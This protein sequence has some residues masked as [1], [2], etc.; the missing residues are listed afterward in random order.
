MKTRI[1]IALML[2]LVFSFFC[3]MSAE[4]QRGPTKYSSTYAW[5]FEGLDS[6][7]TVE[8]EVDSLTG[9]AT[10]APIF[11]WNNLWSENISGIIQ[12]YISAMDTTEVDG[13]TATTPDTTGND[14]I[15]VEIYTAWASQL[16]TNTTGYNRA[17]EKKLLTLYF[18]TMTYS[19]A[20]IET[21]VFTIPADSAVGDVIYARF[22]CFY[23]QPNPS[24]VDTV[25]ITYT[26]GIAMTAK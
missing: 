3:V 8:T 4:A 24:A 14:S 9:G 7:A 15:E 23:T 12:L 5:E 13:D 22:N 2:A 16:T 11:Y 25:S 20:G 21:Q 18:G 17:G 6:S 26:A 10:G 1:L 19:T